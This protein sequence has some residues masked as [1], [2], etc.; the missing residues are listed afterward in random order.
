VLNI[1]KITDHAIL[2]ISGIAKDGVIDISI[3]SKNNSM[4][5]LKSES[6]C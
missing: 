1:P 2:N 4:E 3:N 5:N 6:I